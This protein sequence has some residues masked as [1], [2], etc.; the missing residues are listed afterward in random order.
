MEVE[1]SDKSITQEEITAL[2]RRYIDDAT[3]AAL[4]M[5]ITY[6]NHKE[7]E[8]DHSHAQHIFTTVHGSV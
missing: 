1:T 6:F 4:P 7:A 3:Q 5:T 2:L 8:D